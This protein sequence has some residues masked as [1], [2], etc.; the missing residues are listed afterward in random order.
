MMVLQKLITA[1]YAKDYS[2]LTSQDIDE[3]IALKLLRVET[4]SRI[5]GGCV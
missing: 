2:S 3:L 5:T 4:A 1:F